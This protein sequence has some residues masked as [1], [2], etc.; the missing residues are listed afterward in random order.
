MTFVFH[1]HI[2]CC[3]LILMVYSLK[4]GHVMRS[5][6]QTHCNSDNSLLTFIHREKLVPV[7]IVFVFS[8]FSVLDFEWYFLENHI[9][10]KTTGFHRVQVH[11][12]TRLIVMC[13]NFEF[14][15]NYMFCLHGMN[16]MF[17][18]HHSILG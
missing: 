8:L 4:I 16:I 1:R 14:I 6:H 5:T 2:L 15:G 11:T 17:I 18:F 12:H 13:E 9:A 3:K 10:D 7:F